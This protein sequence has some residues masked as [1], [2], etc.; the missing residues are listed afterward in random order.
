[1]LDVLIFFLLFL[2]SLDFCKFEAEPVETLHL[3]FSLSWHGGLPE[4]LLS[5]TQK[6][7]SELCALREGMIKK[8]ALKFHMKSCAGKPHSCYTTASYCYR[9]HRH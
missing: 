5:D 6:T 9:V 8:H 7:V 2:F 3:S 1:M 4:P